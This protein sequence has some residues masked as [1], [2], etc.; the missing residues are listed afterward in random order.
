[1]KKAPIILLGANLAAYGM[2]AYL[3]SST[4]INRYYIDLYG[5]SKEVFLTQRYYW[6][7]VTSFFLH[8][9]LT[10][11]AYN[12]LFMIVYAYLAEDI[13]PWPKVLAIYFLSGLSVSAVILLAYPN[14]VFAGASGAVLG[15]VGATLA[16]Q[17]MSRLI[18]LGIAV[19]IFFASVSSVY[20]A[21]FTGI[22]T[23]YTISKYLIS[24][25][26]EQHR[27]SIEQVNA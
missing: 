6:Q 5:L 15:L 2:L 23:G 10:H 16:S 19:L 12:L 14:A 8:F 27:N 7:P 3:S 21:H 25:I 9:N 4:N 11:L 22:V 20:L 17:K 18:L 24:K 26:E 13:Y 1:M